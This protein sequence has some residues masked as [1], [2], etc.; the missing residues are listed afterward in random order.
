MTDYQALRLERREG[1]ALLTLNRP[2][3]RNAV[4]PE[5]TQE[6]PRALDEIRRDGEARALVITGTGSVFCAGG[7]L[8]MLG[9]MLEQPPEQNRREMGAFYRTYLDVLNLDV[10]AIAALNGHAVGAGA[11]FTLGCD[12]RLI[13]AGAT[14]GFTF[15]NLGLHPGMGTTHLLPQVV[16]SAHAAELIFTGRMVG[17]EE[18]L[19]M[20]LV[21][22][23]VPPDR[24][25]DE[26]LA[27]AAEMAAKPPSGVRMAKRA[28]ARPKIEGLEAALDYEAAAQMTSYASPEMREAFAALARKQ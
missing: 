12:I 1:V 14:I 26:A 28:L 4:T 23:I 24:L 7:D 6:L 19:A 10:P 17:A 27:L 11:A 5:L 15:L 2:E 8:A 16:G 9:R 3:R 18:A 20:G 25:L 13:A 21:S 22:R